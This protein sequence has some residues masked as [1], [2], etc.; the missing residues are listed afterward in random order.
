MQR[1][2]SMGRRRHFASMPEPTKTTAPSDPLRALVPLSV[3]PQRDMIVRG[4][5]RRPRGFFLSQGDEP[6]STGGLRSRAVSPLFRLWFSLESP[7][8]L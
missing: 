7:G 5:K 2:S 6:W 3:T 4:T 1:T 8:L